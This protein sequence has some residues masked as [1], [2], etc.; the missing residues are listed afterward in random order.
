MLQG[1]EVGFILDGVDCRSYFING[2]LEPLALVAPHSCSGE[3]LVDVLVG[4]GAAISRDGRFG[5]Q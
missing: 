1:I 3:D 5:Q 2:A 4:E